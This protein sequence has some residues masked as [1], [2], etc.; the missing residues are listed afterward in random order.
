MRKDTAAPR[1]LDPV[2]IA[3]TEGQ[4]DPW[5]QFVNMPLELVMEQWWVERKSV[6]SS[7]RG[8]AYPVLTSQGS[9]TTWWELCPITPVEHAVVATETANPEWVALTHLVP[10]QQRAT[11]GVSLSQEKKA[12][13]S[14]PLSVEI[15][16]DLRFD[17][18]YLV[19]IEIKDLRATDGRLR[20]I[21]R[22]RFQGKFDFTDYGPR[23]DYEAGVEYEGR[24]WKMFNH[25]DLH[26]ITG[27]LGVDLRDPG[28]L[29][30]TCAFMEAK[31][32]G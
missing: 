23:L 28:F 11:S 20:T 24:G 8:P 29:T 5:I 26:T 21:S 32:H 4:F 6:F 22:Q 3:G 31:T 2:L 1:G 16:Y 25:D 17:D 12:V 19:W 27:N 15:I 9:P 10:R 14:Q 7:G 13:N 18:S 30:G